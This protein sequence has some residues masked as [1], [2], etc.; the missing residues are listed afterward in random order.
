MSDCIFCKI[1]AK[2]IPADILYE[3]D[4]CMIFPDIHPSAKTHLLIIPK[5]HI[6]TIAD[7]EEGDEKIIGHLIKQA[8]EIAAKKN[9]SGYQLL[10][11]VGKD[12]GQ[13]VFHIHLHLM[14][15]S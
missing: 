8:K 7:M 2:E 4:T 11:R 5:K 15:N 1:I 10:F 12:G 9:L 3:D 14:S 6:P 13:E